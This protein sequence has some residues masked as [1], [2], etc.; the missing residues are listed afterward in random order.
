MAM[1]ICIYGAGAIGSLI[2][3]RLAR[4]G[5]EVSVVEVGPALAAI[6]EHGLRV[7]EKGET[8][9]ARVHATS[10]PV[11]LGRQDLVIVAVK[12]PTLKFIA[13]KIAPLL[14]PDTVVMTAMNGVPWWFF[15]GFGGEYS[16][17]QLRSID[18]DGII[19]AN[20]PFEHVIGCVIMLSCKLVQPGLSEHVSGNKLSIGEPNNNVSLRLRALGSQLS[21]AGF[22]VI[23]SESIQ[24]DIWLK[25]LGNMTH[26]PISALTGATLDRILN[27]PLVSQLCVDAM[28]EAAAVGSKFGCVMSDTPEQ[29]QESTRALGAFKTSM[30]QDVEARRSVEL[31]ALVGAVSEIA[32][33]VGVQTP[34]TDAILGLARVQAQVLGLYPE[35]PAPVK[36][37]VLVAAAK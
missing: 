8:L 1:K 3:L 26:N 33:K 13:P 10:D 37:E 31:D 35:T 29:R 6:Q 2:G 36:E 11:T 20:I 7:I 9:S 15:H 25:L 18:P 16:G 30:L 27:D 24:K 4:Q 5:A 32:K 12:G 21:E 23:V 28:Y 14:G 19:A 22:D 17:T 34:Y